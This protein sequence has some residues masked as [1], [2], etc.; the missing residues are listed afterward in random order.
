V[1]KHGKGTGNLQHKELFISIIMKLII[2]IP[3]NKASSFLD[4]LRSISFVKIEPISPAKIKFLKELKASVD[5][6]MLE[7]EG[8]IEL[9]T[10]EQLLNEL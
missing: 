3:D 1:K 9:K 8:K 6:V 7:K 2:E 10:A 4:A 5:E